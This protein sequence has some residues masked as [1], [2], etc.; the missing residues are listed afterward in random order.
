M[1]FFP[2]DE[3][4]K[5]VAG[6]YSPERT[7]QMVWWAGIVPYADAHHIFER[8]GQADIPSTSLW[9]RVQT[10][11]AKFHAHQQQHQTHVGVERVVLPP[12]GQDHTQRKGL[13]LDGGTM[14][15]RGEGWKEF[16]AGTAYDLALE[17]T[18]DPETGDPSKWRGARTSAIARGW[19]QLLTLLQPCGLWRWTI[20]F[21]KRP[22]WP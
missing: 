13:S 11:G 9:E 18:T 7:K 2:L 17:T 6:L 16:K 20:R 14:H 5:I 12:A 19:G 8:I 3:L 4:W 21:P 1:G 22:T 10:E 15:I